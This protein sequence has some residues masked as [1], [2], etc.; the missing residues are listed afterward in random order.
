L[1]LKKLKKIIKTP[2]VIVNLNGNNDMESVISKFKTITNRKLTIDELDTLLDIFHLEA[3]SR[4][5]KRHR[6]LHN[7]NNNYPFL[8][9]RIKDKVDK[10]KYLYIIQEK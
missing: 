4:K 8:I 7:I 10:R 6:L 3:E 9:N 5:Q 1:F 2:V